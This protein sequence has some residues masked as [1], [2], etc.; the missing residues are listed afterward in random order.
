MRDEAAGSGGVFKTVVHPT[1]SSVYCW[2]ALNFT[3]W[4]NLEART[5]IGTV[6][7]FFDH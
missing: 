1:I 5:C 2:S 4:E 6:A 7:A 3:V